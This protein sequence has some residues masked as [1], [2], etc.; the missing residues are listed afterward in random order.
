LPLRDS[1]S[2]DGRLTLCGARRAVTI[3]PRARR[4]WQRATSTD[5]GSLLRDL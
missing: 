1:P 4:W 3:V 2:R 5:L